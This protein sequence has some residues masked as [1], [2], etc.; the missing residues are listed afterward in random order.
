MLLSELGRSRRRP[1]LATPG[2]DAWARRRR[3]ERVASS[4]DAGC[5]RPRFPTGREPRDRRSP[6]RRRDARP[7]AAAA[8]RRPPPGVAATRRDV[9]RRHALPSQAQTQHR[10][11]KLLNPGFLALSPTPGARTLL[12]AWAARLE[13]AA[14]RNLPP[15]NDAVKDVADSATVCPLAPERFASA[16]RTFYRK[17]WSANAARGVVLAHANW[18]DGRDAKRAAFERAGVWLVE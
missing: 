1:F 15:F 17:S 13:G 2:C 6:R 14:K 16:K 11:K 4:G 9:C 5:V 18:I 12:T 8:P 10:E 3:F 7:P